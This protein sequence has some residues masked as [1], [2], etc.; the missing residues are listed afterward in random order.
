MTQEFRISVTPVGGDEYLVRTER[1]APGVPLAEEQVVWA[2]DD[3]LVQAR[4]LMNDPLLGLLE[5]EARGMGQ[6]TDR[7]QQQLASPTLSLTSLGQQLYNALFQGTIRDSW[8][9]AQGVAQHRREVLR[10]RLG[11]KG[12]KLS[13]L[14]WEVLHAGDRAIATGTDVVFSRYEPSLGL[15]NPIP[16][17]ESF[18]LEPNQPLRILMA[19]AAPTDQDRL[20][21]QREATHLQN[22]LLGGNSALVTSGRTSNSGLFAAE[23]IRDPD[24]L[25][26]M[27]HTPEIQLTLLDQPDREQLTQALEQGNYQVLHYAGHSNPGTEGGNLYLVSRKT[28]L[29]ETLSGDDLAGLLVNNGVR[30]AVFNSCRG[31]YTASS[32][33]LDDTSERNL[34]EAL[35]KRGIPGVLAM[36][37]RIPDD[38]ALTLTRLFYRNLKQG[39]AVDLSLSR[40][41]QGLV[42]AYGSHRLYWALPILYLHSEFN[43]YLSASAAGE[44]EAVNV[45]SRS[46][47]ATR[48]IDVLPT[49]E[50]GTNGNAV[51]IS[52]VDVE[53][54]QEFA[55]PDSTSLLAFPGDLK[56]RDLA[57]ETLGETSANSLHLTQ[58]E[59]LD[60]SDL[61][62]READYTENLADLVDH[63]EYGEESGYE[64]DAALVSDLIRQL[65][66]DEVDLDQDEEEE[67]MILASQAEDLLPDRTKAAEGTYQ[68]LLADSPYDALSGTGETVTE[69]GFNKTSG[70]DA[71]DRTA[72]TALLE[73]RSIDAPTTASTVEDGGLGFWP[74]VGL[75][76]TTL[77]ALLSLLFFSIRPGSFGSLKLPISLPQ[78]TM[79]PSPTPGEGNLATTETAKVTA[80]AIEYLSQGNLPAGQQAVEALL[81]RGALK[82]ANAALAA[83]PN[84]QIDKPA[85]SFLKGRLAWQAVQTGDKDYS[86]SDAR[87]YWETA[88]RKSANPLYQNALGF[89]YYAEGNFNRAD[90]AWFRSLS[91]L[92]ANSASASQ[93]A[94][95]S[96]TLPTIAPPTSDTLTAY[97]GLALVLAKSAQNQPDDRR[98]SLISKAVELHQRVIKDDP[99]NFQPD[100][101]SKNW[102]W[103]EQAIKDWQALQQ[104]QG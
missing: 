40:A 26:A 46:H 89:A 1:V 75:A 16:M 104:L 32:H 15:V 30:M 87:R 13:R 54:E 90:E 103:T 43:G 33:P 86:V 62:Q 68:N 83:V 27:S 65:S 71:A 102:L 52:S 73:S 7:L 3:W 49:Q 28:G 57:V 61:Q 63:L 60:L 101:L 72:L 35:L 78:Y 93:T 5:E 20:E 2:V 38:V 84:S 99:L 18:A 25:A 14:P 47:R 97:A 19:I 24:V 41:R 70:L 94:Q 9:T 8:M 34:A 69:R 88:V 58:A 12:T 66:Q 17:A 48:F 80:L 95:P 22:E 29:T 56:E 21:L 91:L 4:Q 36:A 77:I 51:P 79:Q 100:A 45:L 53:T 85:I 59:S 39:Y 81:D 23:G 98:A 10:L 42:S 67:P 37:E 11:L 82:Q 64:D 44:T 96:K 92:N 6:A 50:L 55:F 76:G 31:A 74:T